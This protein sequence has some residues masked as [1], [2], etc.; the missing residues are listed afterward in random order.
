[1]T[2]TLSFM[3]RKPPGHRWRGYL[4]NLLSAL[5]FVLAA[6]FPWI[7][8]TWRVWVG[9]LAAVS[10]LADGLVAR[11]LGAASAV[12]GHIDAVADKVFVLTVL[13]TFL[14][15]GRLAPWQFPLLLFRDLAVGVIALYAATRRRW[16]AFDVMAA[17][18]PGKVTTAV[19]F[20]YLLV[21]V[22]E[23]AGSIRQVT[24][25]VAMG[26]SSLA[27]ADYLVQ[28]VR[29]RAADRERHGAVIGRMEK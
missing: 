29:T 8:G 4:P 22:T 3:L 17:R 16:D 24:V 15:E 18:W 26:S 27:A 11:R 10:D 20:L 9:V 28:F 13:V 12:G 1:M 5:R 21:T 2:R 6:L 25:A 19:M 23:T 7:G 14:V